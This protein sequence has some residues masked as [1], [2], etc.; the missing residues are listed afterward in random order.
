LETP[1]LRAL[2]FA[3]LVLANIG[4]ILINR[5]FGTS[6]SDV[7]ARP[8][9]SFWFLASL[10]IS[11]LTGALFWKPA[12]HLFEF[13]ALEGWAIVTSLG[14]AA[15]LIVFLEIAKAQLRRHF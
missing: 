3:S 12:Q 6:L 8:N 11:I 15:A 9:P 2:V 4:L 1:D 10:A 14:A 13:G 7:L 5:G